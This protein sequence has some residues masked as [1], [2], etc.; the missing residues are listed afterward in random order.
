MPDRPEPPPS[1]L[2]HPGR[3]DRS[4][5]PAERL[6]LAVLE[7]AVRMFQ[8]YTTADDQRGRRLLVETEEWFASDELEWP[9][10]FVPICDVLGLDAA[11]VRSGLRQWRAQQPRMLEPHSRVFHL[12]LGRPTEEGLHA[13]GSV[14]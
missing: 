3:L 7:N 13:G 5:R 1:L 11:S 12:P 4:P 8:R 14:P 10:A 2:W 6:V 9:F